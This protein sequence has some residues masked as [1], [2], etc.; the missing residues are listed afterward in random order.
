M[1]AFNVWA[2]VLTNEQSFMADIH[3]RSQ[4]CGYTGFLNDY[5]TFPP[6]GKL[7][8]PP[9]VDY[10]TPDCTLWNDIYNAASLVNPSFDMYQILTTP[11]N[12]WDVLGFPGSFDYIP[13]GASIYFNRTDVQKA[14]NAPVQPWDECS[15]GVLTS[16]DSPP[17]GLSVLPR[18]IE[19][20]KKTLILHGGL[21]YIL[22]AN[23]TLL[24]IQN[25]TW[26]GAQGFSTPPSKFNEFFVPYHS[27][28]SLG[29]TAAAG[30]MGA[31]HTERKLT[32]CS[33]DLS[34]HMIPQYQPSASYRQLEFLLGRIENLGVRSD[35]TTQ[36]GN[37]GN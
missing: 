12:L 14:I 33:V 9:N 36:K 28:L 23:G 21:D 27:E 13:D 18:V 2:F 4:H 1:T 19:K 16:D 25:M 30:V 7:P 15:S 11:P 3:N 10:S 22:I 17:S 31:W 8:T 24:M 29:D 5:L 26:G 6:K 20:T 32:Y 34:G 35:F 37:F